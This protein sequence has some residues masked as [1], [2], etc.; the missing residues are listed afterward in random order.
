MS[1]DDREQPCKDINQFTELSWLLPQSM[2]AATVP[3]YFIQN[4]ELHNFMVIA[5]KATIAGISL[6][7]SCYW[8]AALSESLYVQ[9]Q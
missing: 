7:S 4:T 9:K 8:I 1:K 6:G 5:A 3:P 2:Q